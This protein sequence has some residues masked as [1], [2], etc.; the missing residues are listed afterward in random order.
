MTTPTTLLTSASSDSEHMGQGGGCT[1]ATAPLLESGSL[2]DDSSLRLDYEAIFAKVKREVEKDHDNTLPVLT[3]PEPHNNQKTFGE[4]YFNTPFF[5]EVEN[6]EDPLLYDD[7]PDP[8]ILWKCQNFGIS[9]RIL[10][11]KEQNDNVSTKC[12]MQDLLPHFLKEVSMWREE[13]KQVEASF[14][15]KAEKMKRKAVSIS[16]KERKLN[17]DQAQLE[18]QRQGLLRKEAELDARLADASKVANEKLL[19]LTTLKNNLMREVRRLKKDVLA[20]RANA[21]REVKKEISAWVTKNALSAI[22]IFNE[23]LCKS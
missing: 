7:F 6:T 10:A 19:H 15:R 11:M 17:Q 3:K 20:V 21:E 1:T 23:Q 4:A 16:E 12:A 13:A 22:S 8:S 2:E 14:K 18:L 9:S 5:P